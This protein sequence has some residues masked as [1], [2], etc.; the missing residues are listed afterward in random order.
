MR[1]TLR[2][3]STAGK[4]N[5]D[6]PPS[7]A[8]FKTLHYKG[9]EIHDFAWFADKR[10]HVL[11]GRVQLPESGREVTTWVMFTNRQSDLWKDAPGY[12]NAAI[13]YFSKT[14]GDYPYNTFTAVQSALS[15]GVGMEYPGLTVIGLADDAYALDEVLAHEICHNWFYSALG[16]DERRYP[17]MDEGITRQVRPGT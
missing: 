7:S 12:V 10:F 3:I 11:T 4:L 8:V 15:S 14:I 17:F 5:D 6:F 2:G 9:K 1:Q 13:E 16:S